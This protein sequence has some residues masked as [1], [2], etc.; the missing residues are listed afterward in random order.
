[1]NKET[2]T[3]EIPILDNVEQMKV[4]ETFNEEQLWYVCA[5]AKAFEKQKEIIDKIK[6]TLESNLSIM[7]KLVVISVLLKKDELLEEIE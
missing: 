5:I 4:V 7:E 1:M 6:E 3:V 2:I